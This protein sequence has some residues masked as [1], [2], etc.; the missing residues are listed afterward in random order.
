MQTINNF[1]STSCGG[2]QLADPILVIFCHALVSV[3]MLVPHGLAKVQPFRSANSQIETLN[4][5]LKGRL[6]ASNALWNT[7][8]YLK[9]RV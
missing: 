8:L 5:G 1:D 2:P 3:Q 9:L 6:Q 7:L 4:C